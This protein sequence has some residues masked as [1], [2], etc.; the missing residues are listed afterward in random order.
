MVGAP[1]NVE[2]ALNEPPPTTLQ[3]T[4]ALVPSLARVAAKA[5]VAPPDM[6]GGLVGT[7]ATTMGLRVM[8][9]EAHL[10][11]SLM[12]VAVSVTLVVLLSTVAGAL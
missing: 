4:P 1:L 11:G 10:V 6:D 5:W 7:T 9:A 8:V 12:L 3:L 2:L